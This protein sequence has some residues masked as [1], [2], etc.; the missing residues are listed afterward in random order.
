MLGKAH[1]GKKKNCM[2]C[3]HTFVPLFIY[4]NIM[5]TESCKLSLQSFLFPQASWME[6]FGLDGEGRLRS[7]AAAVGEGKVGAGRCG[8]F[9]GGGG[10]METPR[11]TTY[12]TK[13]AVKGLGR[14]LRPR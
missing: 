9:D 8:S 5:A 3:H 6:V 1:S 12:G 2:C 10:R 7:G 11:R 14:P 13:R 4:R